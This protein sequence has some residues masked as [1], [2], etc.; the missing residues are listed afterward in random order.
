[1][2][3]LNEYQRMGFANRRAYLINLADQYGL[4]RSEVFMM[5]DML[6]PNEDFDGLV[7]ELEDYSS[8]SQS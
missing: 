2:E 1:M 4:P 6:G 7:T 8:G 3:E 5:A